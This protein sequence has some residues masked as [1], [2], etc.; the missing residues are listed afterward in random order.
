MARPSVRDQESSR[1]PVPRQYGEGALCVG[2]RA[3]ARAPARLCITSLSNLQNLAGTDGPSAFADREALTDL[4]GDR[5]H[6]LDVHVE[7]IAGH[8]H[9]DAFRQRDGARHV[10]RTEPEVRGIATHEWRV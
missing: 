5:L 10:G 4:E 8:D 9:L 6:Q 2:G 3:E 7:R 1:A